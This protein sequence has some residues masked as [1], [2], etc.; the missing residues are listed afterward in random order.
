MG[1][2]KTSSTLTAK[3][4]PKGREKLISSNSGLITK[5]AL[6]DSDANYFSTQTLASGEI[7]SSGG[8]L[9]STSGV[10]SNSVTTNVKMIDKLYAS[11]TS[12][13]KNVEVGSSRLI[14]DYNA[15]G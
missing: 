5:F 7:P 14:T 13:F 4:T 12:F 8:D 15:I 9:T 3:F 10:S 11:P 1:Y 2:N 6:G